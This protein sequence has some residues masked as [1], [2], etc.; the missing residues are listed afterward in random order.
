MTSL[1]V[2]TPAEDD[3]LS[4]YDME[5]WHDIFVPL[6]NCVL[7]AL[8]DKR[9]FELSVLLTS[10]SHIQELNHQYRNK[11]KPTN[12][13]SFPQLNGEDLESPATEPI[14]LGDVV[15]A[16]QTILSESIQQEKTF[17]NHVTHLFIHSC[18]HLFGYDH[19]TEDEAHIMENL[20]ITILAKL[21]IPNPYSIEGPN[22]K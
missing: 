9:S 2:V 8:N 19:E 18:L 21:N 14:L 12:V 3:W 7:D 17:M 16:Y 11:D 4:H 5:T 1:I 20:E 10:D 15:M 13:L 6:F 22:P